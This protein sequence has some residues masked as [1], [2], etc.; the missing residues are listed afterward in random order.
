[1]E[2]DLLV[3]LDLGSGGAKAAVFDRTGEIV[4]LAQEEYAFDRPRPGIS[5]IAAE[6]VWAR[7]C[8][9]LRKVTGH[10]GLSAER[11][12]GVGLSVIG[13]TGL[14][15][16]EQGRPLARAIESM[17]TREAGYA[18][19]VGWWQER[20]GA[21]AIFARTSY[22]LN[23]LATAIKIL[24]WKENCPDLYR[25]AVRFA[26]FQ[27][28][29]VWQLCGR[30]AIDYSMASRTM[31]FDVA[32]KRWIPEYLDVL[33]LEAS[34]FSS[35]V[36]GATL[37]G[38]VTAAASALTGLPEGTP[39]VPGAHDQA[40]AALGVGVVRPGVA[41]DGTGSVEAIVVP[42]REPITS[43]EML[44]VGH[45]S[46]CHV[47]GD[48]YLAIGFHLAAGSLV[49]WYRD[50][51][52]E[53]EQQRAA[54]SGE[55]AYD[56]LTAAASGSPPGANGLLVLP[57]I[58]GGGTGR[59]PALNAVS[60]G[61]LIGLHIGHTKADLTRA[62]FEGVT[63]EARHIIASME[64]GGIPISELVVT[65][66]GARSPFWLQLKADITQ[67]RVVVPAVT[68]ASLLGAAMLAGLG[69]GVYGDLEEAAAACCRVRATYEPNVAL[70]DTYDGLFAVYEDLYPAVIGLNGRLAALAQRQSAE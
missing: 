42:T 68:E 21:E 17:D 44:A 8:A 58:S 39:V 54:A 5:E 22:P 45:G 63:Y 61:V 50:Q 7:A 6:D 67:R 43:P 33:G 23:A 32:R 55:D 25:R 46:Q 27:D 24:W 64:Q 56:L 10:V 14:P 57:H 48:L 31:L 3:G 65:G 62:V 41:A 12:A 36:E 53:S 9:V 35:P 30:P 49:R 18:R 59:S 29:A 34:R 28:Y 37:V 52:G 69:A 60:R 11:I 19:Y 51:L 15:L 40:C 66:G 4:A 2:R 38:L 70:R 47:R 16:D 20:F 13:E 26:T 1:M